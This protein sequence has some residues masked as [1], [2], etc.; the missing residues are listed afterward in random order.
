MS[1]VE[2]N[3]LLEK[4]D[5]DRA[6]ETAKSIIHYDDIKSAFDATRCAFKENVYNEIKSVFNTTRRVVKEN[7]FDKLPVK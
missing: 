7:V 6:M 3:P 4:G 2:Q 1:R 5:F